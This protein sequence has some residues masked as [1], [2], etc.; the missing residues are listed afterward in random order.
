MDDGAGE[1]GLPKT[2]IN[3]WSIAGRDSIKSSRS[4][5]VRVRDEQ[6]LKNLARNSHLSR[7]F[8]IQ[9]LQDFFVFFFVGLGSTT[10]TNV[11]IIIITQ[12]YTM[13]THIHIQ[14]ILGHIYESTRCKWIR[15]PKSPLKNWKS[16]AIPL[17]GTI[18]MNFDTIV[19]HESESH[20]F[21]T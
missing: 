7:P 18:R 6:R 5:G 8:L 16:R 14:V 10:S 13:Y 12:R 17:A 2:T 20:K 15:N 21:G 11:S 19:I 4:G 3:Q 9:K 1:E